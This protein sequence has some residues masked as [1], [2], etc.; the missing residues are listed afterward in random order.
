[1]EDWRG[2]SYGTVA[3][4]ADSR[5]CVLDLKR[6]VARRFLMPVSSQYWIFG[7]QLPSDES[8]LDTIPRRPGAQAQAQGA[9]GPQQILNAVL[10]VRP[11][12]PN[13]RAELDG[14]LQNMQAYTRTP[15][16]VQSPPLPSRL[17]RH[18]VLYFLDCI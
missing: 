16:P 2:T 15:P 17:H 6:H 14:N 11:A 4:V 1:M 13:D 7:K 5:W 8:T 18:T 9:A 3:I 12:D 10:Y